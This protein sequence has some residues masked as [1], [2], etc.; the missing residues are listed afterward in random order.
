MKLRVS[1][2]ICRLFQA[3]L[4]GKLN[5]H[6]RFAEEKKKNMKDLSTAKV[7]HAA[8]KQAISRC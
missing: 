7:V 5:W 8:A 3:I 2:I 1:E 6:H 4:F